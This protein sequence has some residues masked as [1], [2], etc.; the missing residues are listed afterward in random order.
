MIEVLMPYYGDPGLLRVAVQSV[1]DQD[2]DDWTLVVVD[3]DYPDREPGRWVQGLDDPR[4]TYVRN[5]RNL[6]VSGNLRRCLEIASAEYFVIMGADDAMH[7]DYVSTIKRAIGA[8]PDAAMLQPRVQVIDESGDPIA[9]LGDRIKTLLAPSADQ[10]HVLSGQELATTLLQGNWL[11]F[12]ALTWNRSKI[13]ALTFRS[14]M[15]TVFDLDFLMN[16]II[17]GASLVLLEEQAFS[18]RRHASSVSSVTARD[19]ARFVEEARLFSELVPRLEQLGW[20]RAA[21]AARLHPTSRLHAVTLLPGALR[22]RDG[23]IARLLVRHAIQ[24]GAASRE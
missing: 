8:H 15:E 19:T 11:Y 6:G 10:A 16:L 1:L 14:D 24:R 21:R 18:Y 12:P 23:S 2:D 20:S 13:G 17:D 9:P 22:S 7:G 3:N 4:V 5:D